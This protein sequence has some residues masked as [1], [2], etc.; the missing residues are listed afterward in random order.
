[1]KEEDTLT[2]G[3]LIPRGARILISPQLIHKLSKHW[4]E[5]SE[6]DPTRF[7]S[8]LEPSLA[9]GVTGASSLPRAEGDGGA[10]MEFGS[11][12]PF[13]IGPKACI[14]TRFAIA[15]MTLLLAILVD[16]YALRRMPREGGG[17]KSVQEALM[18]VPRKKQ[19]EA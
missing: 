18:T 14:A 15:E 2:G 5:P 11:Y 4:P 19:A 13:S 6:F 3:F 10:V 8:S 16:A 12:L 7:V 17:I 9:Y 1:L